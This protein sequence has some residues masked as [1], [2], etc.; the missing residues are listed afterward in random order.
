MG[1]RFGLSFGFATDLFKQGDNLKKLAGA[2][3]GGAAAKVYSNANSAS[4]CAAVVTAGASNCSASGTGDAV[5]LNGL[6]FGLRVE[7]D[8]LPWLFVRTGGNFIMGLKNTYELTSNF[9]VGGVDFTDKTTVTANGTIIEIPA[10]IGVNL[11]QSDKGSVYF[12]GGVAYNIA[13]YNYNVS[14]NRTQS[15][16]TPTTFSDVENKTKQ[17]GLG[18][19]WLVGGRTRI[20]EGVTLFGEVKF[21]A[22]AAVKADAVTGTTNEAGKTYANASTGGLASSGFLFS[23]AAAGAT[24]PAVIQGNGSNFGGTASGTGGLDLSYTRWQIGVTYDL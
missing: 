7:Y 15:A 20:V 14:G 17:N 5:S 19:M 6:D 10:L 12:A 23:S 8:I 9:T 13:E 18:I 11:V 22:A 21:L 24:A 3:G 4:Q 1:L 16:G 2:A